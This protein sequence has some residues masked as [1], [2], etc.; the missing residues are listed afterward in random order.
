MIR[1]DRKRAVQRREKSGEFVAKWVLSTTRR[2]E[3]FLGTGCCEQG[4]NTGQTSEKRRKQG[5]IKQDGG[6]RVTSLALL[7]K[8]KVLTAPKDRVHFKLG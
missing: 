7:P 8:V 4:N 2:I 6:Q 3:K 1:N 5:Q